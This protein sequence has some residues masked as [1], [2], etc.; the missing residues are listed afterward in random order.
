VGDAVAHGAGSEYGDGANLAEI[1][2]VFVAG[3]K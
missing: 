2:I 1:H 3:S